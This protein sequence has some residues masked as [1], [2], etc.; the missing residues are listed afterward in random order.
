MHWRM[1]RSH[2]RF[3]YGLVRWAR[4]PGDDGGGGQGRFHHTV[5]NLREPVKFQ[6]IAG[7]TASDVGEVE[8]VEAPAVG[9]F[10]IRYQYPD[11]T[12]LPSKIEEGSG[13]IETLAGSEVRIEMAANKPIARGQLVFDDNTQLPLTVRQD[14]LLQATAIITRPG[15]YRVEVQDDLGF[16]N[17]ENLSY[18]IEVIPDAAP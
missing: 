7:S 6:A 11:Y 12:R 18:R 17:Q 16:A 10:R 15:G 3:I 9:N 1:D 4:T 13:H 8:V 14:G 2:H 5:S